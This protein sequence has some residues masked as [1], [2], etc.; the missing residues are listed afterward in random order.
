MAK[1]D[2]NF[3]YIAIKLSKVGQKYPLGLCCLIFSFFWGLFS[4]LKGFESNAV[5]R[6]TGCK[7]HRVRSEPF[8][9]PPAPGR[10]SAR[11]YH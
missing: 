11:P 5:L 1:T 9:N 7:L 2:I 4:D 6:T 8:P 10:H 3:I